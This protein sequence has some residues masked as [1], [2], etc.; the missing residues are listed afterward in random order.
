MSFMGELDR[1]LVCLDDLCEWLGE[2]STSMRALYDLVEKYKDPLAASSLSIFA[3]RHPSIPPS[4]RSHVLSAI[5][6]VAG[7][8][9]L[10]DL[11]QE[12]RFRPNSDIPTLNDEFE[13]CISPELKLACFHWMNLI[14]QADHHDN[15]IQSALSSLQPILPFWIVVMSFTGQLDRALVCLNDLCEWLGENST[16]TRALYDY[17]AKYENPLSISSLSILTYHHSSPQPPVLPRTLS[18]PIVSSGRSVLDNPT[19]LWRF[20]TTLSGWIGG[21]SFVLL[22]FPI[23]V[24]WFVKQTPVYFFFSSLFAFL[25]SLFAVT[26]SF[27]LFLFAL[28]LPP[29]LVE[30][31][32]T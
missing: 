12:W 13:R 30:R 5:E 14:C 28:L 6:V 27:L 22:L 2:K 19:S 16:S 1:A 21:R 20:Q 31:F 24:V 10:D 7:C 29:F 18:P 11:P 9:A 3:Y 4:S 32:G 8:C 17:V 26:F 15:K 23:F 25:F